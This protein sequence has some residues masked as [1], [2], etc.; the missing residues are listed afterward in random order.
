MQYVSIV[1][2]TVENDFL[3]VKKRR[4]EWQAGK[5]NFPG[6]K[7]E[8]GE[9]HLEAALRE[10]R[11]EVQLSLWPEQ[12]THFLTMHKLQQFRVHFFKA[13]IPPAVM[14]E[15]IEGGDE[16]LQICNLREPWVKNKAVYGVP[17]AMQLAL[18]QG[19]DT[20]MYVRVQSEYNSNY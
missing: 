5:L 6:G 13:Q 18:M 7:I 1:L 4:P 19:L 17:M 10:L 14:Y 8:P 11:E 16:P 20:P 3:F 15:A 12:L 9:T 2:Y